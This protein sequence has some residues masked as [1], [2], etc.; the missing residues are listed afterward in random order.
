[1]KELPKRLKPAKNSKKKGGGG[2]LLT[3][4]LKQDAQ[5]I[6]KFL[7]PVKASGGG[8]AS[9]VPN[10]R[11][12]SQA[13]SSKTNPY[14]DEEKEMAQDHDHQGLLVPSLSTTA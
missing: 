5:A 1:M 13:H 3:D 4:D 8:E 6:H 2:S 11:Q 9:M 7:T 14:R 12:L 10:D